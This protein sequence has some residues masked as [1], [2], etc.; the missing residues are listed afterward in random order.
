MDQNKKETTCAAWTL[1]RKESSLA[2]SWPD[3]LSGGA[4]AVTGAFIFCMILEALQQVTNIYWPKVFRCLSSPFY[5]YGEDLWQ[6]QNR[7]PSTQAARCSIDKAQANL[8][9]Q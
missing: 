2:S 6:K 3:L 9:S 5:V 4:G 1:R 7:K 8:S